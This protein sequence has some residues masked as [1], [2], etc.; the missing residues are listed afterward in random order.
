ML[1][2]Q[3]DPAIYIRQT[4]DR[5]EFTGGGESE[6]LLRAHAAEALADT[7]P[8]WKQHVVLD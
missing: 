6:W 4:D 7:W 1:V 2:R 3:G 8:D 5:V